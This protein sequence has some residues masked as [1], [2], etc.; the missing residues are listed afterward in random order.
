MSNRPLA[1]MVRGNLE[2]P[3]NEKAKGSSQSTL[4]KLYDL[5]PILI[6]VDR[7]R[8]SSYYFG[9]LLMGKEGVQL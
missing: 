8:G 4:E 3:D 6:K 7:K 1:K 2:I 5:F 9:Q